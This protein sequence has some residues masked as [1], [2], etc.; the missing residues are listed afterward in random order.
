MKRLRLTLSVL[1]SLVLTY[2]CAETGGLSHTPPPITISPT[3]APA[4]TVALPYQLSLSATGG[5]TPYNWSIV[6]GSLPD[7]L[8][9]NTS[10]GMIS[11]TPT[12]SGTANFT[13]E[14]ADSSTPSRSASLAYSIAI[15]GIL[16]FSSPVLPNGTVGVA[17]STTPSI[18]GGAPPYTW[19]VVSGSLPPGLLLNASTGA[20]TGT[21]T[22]TGSF[23][24]GIQV[25]DSSVPPQTAKVFT[26]IVINPPLA[27]VTSALASGAV[28][29]PYSATLIASG[30]VNQL[31]WSLNAGALP[32]GL[33][34]SAAG[35]ISG[36][37]TAAGTANFTAQVNDSASPPRTATASFALV[38]NA[39]FTITNSSAQSG[40]VGV[41]YSSSPAVNGGT[42]P[43]LWS[44]ASGSLP[45]GL[46]LNSAT[47][48]ITGVPTA[49]GS[50]SFVLQATDSSAPAETATCPIT[51][52][53]YAPLAVGT[54]ALPT[55]VAGGSYGATLAASN[56]VGS[57][58][59]A[60]ISGSL[61]SGLT[62][63][64]GTGV[65]SG[66]VSTTGVSNFTVQVT[67]SAVP[68]RT[69]S[70]TLS[71]T[72][73]TALSLAHATMPDGVTGV[74]YSST[75]TASGGIT[76]YTWS[77]VSGSLPFGMTLSSSTGTISGTCPGSGTFTFSVRVAD[78]STPPQ[79]ATVSETIHVYGQLTI[80]TTTLSD[81]TANSAYSTTLQAFGGNGVYTW[82]ISSG[83]L[84]TG[85]TLDPST[86]ILSGTP[87]SAG[88]ANFTAQVVDTSNPAQ[89]ASA[90]LTLTV[91]PAGANNVHLNGSYAILFQ[92]FDS[93]G[94]VAMVGSIDAD[95]QGNVTAGTL[96][97][98][99]V[100]GAQTQVAIESG[101]YSI[102]GD[103]RGTMTLNSAIG[104]QTF[105]VAV[106]PS[107]LLAHFI[108]FDSSG[109]GAIR[110]NG[111]MKRRDPAGFSNP[112]ISGSYAFGLSGTTVGG[113]R[114]VLIGAF[115]ADGAG[116]ISA[117]LVDRNS[118]GLVNAMATL[119][120][121][122]NYSIGSD[123]RGSLA[124]RISGI[125]DVSGV[126]YVVSAKDLFF[127]R[128][129][130]FTGGNDLL[131]GEILQQTGAP[132][133][134]LPL[135]GT[136]VL[137]MEGA[138]SPA[139]TIAGAGIVSSTAYGDLSGVYDIND[140]GAVTS[141]AAAV[142]TYSVTSPGAGRGTMS[143]AGNRWTFYLVDSGAGFVMDASNNV[144]MGMFEAQEPGAALAP[145]PVNGSF[146]EGSRSNSRSTV[147]FESGTLD[148]A[149]TGAFTGVV[150]LNAPGN[151]TMGNMPI[152]G[153]FGTSP[154]GRI[155]DAA[156][157]IYYIVSNT[158]LVGLNSESGQTNPTIVSVDQ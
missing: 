23:S 111:V 99:R 18:T 16:E 3:T 58:S 137:H 89:I 155:A 94:A 50:S 114:S 107:G 84:P 14:L 54:T 156:G 133:S 102:N 9:L 105:Q 30:G 154:N 142:G 5:T 78:S 150:D 59:W 131:S 90:P 6:S 86:G 158:H 98:N 145:V 76:P 141:N 148:L 153:A 135:V 17:Y 40:T 97:I 7:G 79:T 100:G 42:A 113:S 60:I 31:T 147:T 34:L 36:T 41:A 57:T 103:N 15:N 19:S 61:P 55:A 65:I 93:N 37:P 4:G 28:N 80:T 47:G 8:S 13:V 75:L 110:G 92:G 130:A 51:I 63:N 35:V 140:G 2:G 138:S 146:V 116:G 95:G 25:T 151:H 118:A 152:A 108:A 67:D 74:P 33:S 26:G 20:I 115:S 124:L 12:S 22:T 101:T 87:A 21:P 38:I 49:A 66:T 122:S 29:A 128:M 123:G 96:D 1:A 88:T 157:N 143:F 149:R 134:S 24:V 132:F 39:H 52:V 71:I 129:D 56:A 48:A 139:S 120:P 77:V 109:S 10:S 136:S 144:M 69:A 83:S 91:G 44:I 11:G 85:I 32:V 82:S 64:P 46:T 106:T 62:L 127:V 104:A 119:T 70:G 81:A 72:T 112:G 121:E 53:I 68:P 117:G 126:V 125:G 43:Y 27:I 45:G 73:T